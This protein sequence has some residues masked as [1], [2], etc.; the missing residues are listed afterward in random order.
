[1]GMDC[2]LGAQS[3]V[4]EAKWSADISLFCNLITASY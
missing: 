4:L 2:L 3:E 1:M